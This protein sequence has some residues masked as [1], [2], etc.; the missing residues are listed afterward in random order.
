MFKIYK[1]IFNKLTGKESPKKQRRQNR[2]KLQPMA[3]RQRRKLL[4]P[5]QKA[6]ILAGI[7]KGAGAIIQTQTKQKKVIK[8]KPKTPPPAPAANFWTDTI[9]L[10]IIKPT[11]KQ[12]TI[13]TGVTIAAAAIAYKAFK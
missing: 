7:K 1:N 8:T 3:T 5:E 10:G 2:K 6:K 11:G 13:G 4:S 12:L 9:D